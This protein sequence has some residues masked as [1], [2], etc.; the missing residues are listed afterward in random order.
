MAYLLSREYKRGNFYLYLAY[1]G[2]SITD[3]MAAV[4]VSPHCLPA[5]LLF[6]GGR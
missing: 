4:A 5:L 2:F 1:L 3:V 6:K